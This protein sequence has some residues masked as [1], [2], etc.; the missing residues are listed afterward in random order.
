[1]PK[2][3]RFHQE[4]NWARAVRTQVGRAQEGNSDGIWRARELG[5]SAVRPERSAVRVAS[6]I[7]AGSAP[8]IADLLTRTD[9]NVDNPDL[10][11]R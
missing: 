11:D 8:S 9:Q 7:A 2:K 10:T 6:R 5:D 3:H 1:M 4:H